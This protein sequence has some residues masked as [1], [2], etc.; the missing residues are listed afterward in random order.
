MYGPTKSRTRP[1]TGKALAFTSSLG[2]PI[3]RASAK[4]QP[5]RRLVPVAGLPSSAWNRAL[6]KVPVG[7]LKKRLEKVA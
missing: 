7:F 4:G 1:K 6:K 3:F 2:K 5:R